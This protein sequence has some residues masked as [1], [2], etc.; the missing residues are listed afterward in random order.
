MIKT[1]FS[2]VTI[3]CSLIFSGCSLPQIPQEVRLAESQNQ[4]LLKS[5]ADSYSPEEYGRYQKAL[6]TAQEHLAAE[7]SRFLLFR[8][9]AKIGN[10]FRDILK[11]GEEV[12]NAALEQ[13][14]MKLNNI[15]IQFSSLENRIRTLKELTYKINEGRLARKDLIKAE[16]ILAETGILIE[17]KEHLHAEDK[18]RAADAYIK[19]AE[20]KI[21]PIFNR[22][23]D[24]GLLH[25]WQRWFEETIA[26]SRARSSMAI[27]INKSERLLT[28]Y[29]NGTPA[30][31][32]SVGLGRNG[33][34]D[35]MHAGDNA[36]P[37]GRYKIIK[38]LPNSQYYKALLIN[39]PNEEDKRQFVQNKKMGIVPV[40]TGIGGL[41]E[42]HGGGKDSMTHGCIA[43]DNSKIDEVY[44]L[45]DV[46]T[47]VTIVG[48]VHPRNR[49]STALEG[50]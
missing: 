29:K 46:G 47:P 17:K 12:R 39:Y 28:I 36:T 31:T 21:L 23:A 30:K 42:I 48:A 43:M 33:S 7:N 19:A 41:I 15:L 16:L 44:R 38:K 13:K 10:E 32:Y 8:N 35:K 1:V 22:Y 37:E 40:K 3:L 14:E 25:K 24:R 50:L 2:I 4:D 9:Y 6:T 26:E 5:G 18:F 45:V 27:I 20:E 49:L 34:T 11:A